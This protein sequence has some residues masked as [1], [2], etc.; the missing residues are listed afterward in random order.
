MRHTKVDYQQRKDLPVNDPANGNS[1]GATASTADAQSRPLQS[2]A[3]C[4]IVVLSD[5]EP[6]IIKLQT[7]PEA[8]FVPSSAAATLRNVNKI[9]R[10]SLRVC[11]TVCV[12]LKRSVECIANACG[13]NRYSAEVSTI[14]KRNQ[15][16]RPLIQ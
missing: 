2:T 8:A 4:S 13:G 16:A 5:V 7:Q 10:T 15:E 1:G 3:A 6:K 9:A 12:L 14:A 11:I